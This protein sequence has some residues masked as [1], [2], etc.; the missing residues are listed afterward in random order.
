MNLRQFTT[1]LS[2][3]IYHKNQPSLRLRG[4]RRREMKAINLFTYT[5]VQPDY[6]TEYANLLAQREA[7]SKFKKHEYETLRKFVG[8][9]RSQGLGISALEGFFYSFKIEQ[10]G[11]EFDLLK[12]EKDRLVLNIELKS[13]LIEKEKIRK[14]LEQN[15]YYLKHLA[16]NI[17]LYTFVAETEEIYQYVG[18]DIINVTCDTLI[19]VMRLFSSHICEGIETLFE[20]RR[21]LISPL[22]TPEEFLQGQ[23]FLTLQQE[24]IKKNI[25]NIV[26]NVSSVFGIT[27]KAGTGKTLLLYDIARTLAGSE[28][29]CCVI[30]S[31][32][33]CEGHDYLN[34]YWNNV[35]VIAA[36]E[37]NGNGSDL[38][39]DYDFIFV[40]ESQRI[41]ES[42][43]KKII[44]TVFD[45][46][47]TAIFSYDFGQALSYTEENR[48]IPD[49]L[50]KT[51]GF[52]EF[53]LSEKIRTSKEIASFYKNL[54][55]LN[56]TARTY[57]NYTNIDV[58]YA[59]DVKEA[60]ELI[61]LYEKNFGYVFIS[62]TQSVYKPGSIDAYPNKH[63][64]HHVIGQEY[65]KVMIVIDDNFRYDDDGR[66]QG[67]IHPNPDYLFYKLLYQGVS[68]SR[69]KLCVL[70]V[71]NYTM[72]MQISNIKYQMLERY[73]YKEN[74][75]SRNISFK[76]LN[77][78]EKT[79]KDGLTELDT[80][81]AELISDIVIMIK[82]ELCSADP[83]KK[84]INNGM[85]F[86]NLILQKNP[87][88]SLLALNVNNYIKYI[89]QFA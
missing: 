89:S 71:N 11:K 8:L 25:L 36:K 22:N 55:D 19:D 23:Y 52:H 28:N 53:S 62:Y 68:R 63:D 48:N 49:L 39:L 65:D 47:K 15:E 13:E 46:G 81:D 80:D 18:G 60:L 59:N 72:F 82:D 34:K 32:I 30:H 78:M 87:E 64:T 33:L 67:R 26:E 7:K 6:S 12:I 2:R 56:D 77:R 21:Y 43:V 50:R 41:Y 88:V 3:I 79:I 85:K 14:Q 44:E 38:L 86:I 66:I 58:L 75:L 70:V 20:A 69:E 45:G 1:V 57:M 42:T 54:L 84:V 61:D 73:Q 76:E 17:K 27:G 9:L 10:I 4:R 74:L 40:D 29:K 51:E 24:E 37:L 83:K 16:N 31:G 5:R 35:S